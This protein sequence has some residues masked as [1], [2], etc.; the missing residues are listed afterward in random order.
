MTSSNWFLQ[1]GRVEGLSLLLL[2]FFAMP[3]KY[4]Y[5]DPSYVKVVGMAHGVLFVVYV[6]LAYVVYESNRWSLKLLAWCL[7]LSSL[8]FGTFYFERKYRDKICAG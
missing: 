6:A 4:L 2:F 8:P 7:V 5:G 1:V 3:M